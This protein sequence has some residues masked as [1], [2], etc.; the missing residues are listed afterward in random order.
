MSIVAALALLLPEW[1]HGLAHHHAAA[2]H[3]A[4]QHHDSS[5]HAAHD[6][7]TGGITSVTGETGDDGHPHLELIATAPAKPLPIY[8]TVVRVVALLAQVSEE[9]PLQPS[10]A[11][12]LSP[13]RREH[14]PPPPSRAPPRI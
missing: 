9:R 3:D 10:A 4:P 8:A 13:R 5:R 12:D 14:G 2:H 1:G 7:L 6:R 11:T